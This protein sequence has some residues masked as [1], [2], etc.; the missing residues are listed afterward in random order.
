MR[1]PNRRHAG[2]ALTLLA[3]STIPTPPVV[4]QEWHVGAQGGWIRSSLDPSAEAVGSISAGLRYEAPRTAFRLVGGV[5]TVRDEPL[6]GSASLWQRLA[7]RGGRGFLAGLDLSGVG[8]VAHDRQAAATPAPVPGNGGGI[9]N[10]SP[11]QSPPQPLAEPDRSG[12]AL[13]VQALPLVGYEGRDVQLHARGGVSHFA[14]RFGDTRLDRTVVLADLQ[15]TLLPT[16]SVALVPAVRHYRPEEEPGVTYSAMTVIAASA[17]TRL[18]GSV[19]HWSGVSGTGTPWA[20]GARLRVGPRVSLEVAARHDA[21][22]PLHLQ[23]A[24]TSGSAGVSIQIGGR[25]GPPPLPIPAAYAN[26]LATL[27]LPAKLTNSP[28]SIAGDFTN[29]KPV[30]MER[31]D[32]VWRYTLRLPPGVYRYAFVDASGRWFVPEGVPG[33]RDDGMGGH[34]AVVVVE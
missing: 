26:G 20:V 5:P 22:D 17:R 10:P 8:F 23:P 4:A 30:P 31:H 7:T 28:P 12:Q 14:A 25:T 21:F 6:W 3:V 1:A 19:G 9:L 33:R 11:P 18:S 34:V 13:A 16:R 2:L 15:L 29:W 27:E 32:K 24:Q